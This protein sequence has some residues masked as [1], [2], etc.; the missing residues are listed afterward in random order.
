MNRT[1]IQWTDW[2]WNPI[3][4][5]S[6]ASEGCANC[7]A[8][9]ISKRFHLPWGSA[10][11]L[12]ERLD[13]PAKVRKPGRVFVCS[14]ADIGHETVQPEWRCLIARAMQKAPQHQYII[15]TK[16]PGP[17][18]DVFYHTGAWAGVTIELQEHF[19]RLALLYD[20]WRGVRFVSVEPM[21]GPVTFSDFCD[22]ARP[23]WVIAGPET[24]PKRRPC[25]PAWIDDLAAESPCFF[26]K[27]EPWARREWPDGQERARMPHDAPEG[28]QTQG[29]GASKGRK[30][31]RRDEFG[32]REGRLIWRQTGK[33][34]GRPRQPQA[35]HG[36]QRIGRLAQR[37][38]RD[39]RPRILR[40]PRKPSVSGGAK[41]RGS[42]DRGQ[43]TCTKP[44]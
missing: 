11:F 43:T 44:S 28:I 30:A 18:L 34:A 17:W 3:V 25:N 7:Y 41:T 6:P 37:L 2:T 33:K 9:A 1:G 32:Q 23:N 35:G 42:M 22:Y 20:Y 29:G 13:Q 40:K 27:R 4:G 31:G 8:A 21:L 26:D 16:R 24:G 12:P 5:C 15:L 39:T 14:M 10:H 36:T 38:R 19:V